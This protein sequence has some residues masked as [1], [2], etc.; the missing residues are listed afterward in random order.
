[1]KHRISDS[2]APQPSSLFLA[3]FWSLL[4]LPFQFQLTLVTGSPIR[5]VAVL[6]GGRAWAGGEVESPR[7][8]ERKL[9]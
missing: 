9:L 1:M 8:M 6:G 2:S 5:S 4:L 7:G 3:S